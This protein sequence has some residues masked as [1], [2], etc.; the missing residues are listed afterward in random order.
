MLHDGVIAVN[1][2]RTAANACDNRDFTRAEIKLR[3]DVFRMAEILRD[4]FREFKN[5]YVSSVAPQ[6]GVRE[7]RRILGSYTVTG[8]EYQS[9]YRYEDSISRGAHPIDI[10][11]A[12]GASQVA[13]F[14]K[15]AAYVP[16]RALISADFPN[17]LV[18]G[19]CL[20]ADRQAFAALRVQASCMGLGQAAGISAAMCAKGNVNVQNVDVKALKTKLK[21]LGTAI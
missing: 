13:D 15:Q 7:T 16:Y 19:R 11:S 20:S 8:A 5:C 6:A 18:A 9:A 14:L 1:M 2:T 4:N 3:E 21:D 10:H 12:K 17:L